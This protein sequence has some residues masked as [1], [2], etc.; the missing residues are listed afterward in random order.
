M[1][2]PSE[3]T[4]EIALS[5]SEPP[6]FG[7]ARRVL[8]D[9]LESETRLERK[10]GRRAL[11][12][13]LMAM[14]GFA[15][16]IELLAAAGELTWSRMSLPVMTVIVPAVTISWRFLNEAQRSRAEKRKMRR[17][18]LALELMEGSPQFVWARIEREILAP[19]KEVLPP[20]SHVEADGPV[21]AVLPFPNWA[22]MA[23]DFVRPRNSR[24]PRSSSGR[25]DER[26]S[27]GNGTPG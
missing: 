14:A 11:L 16:L 9:A 12:F 10:A 3:D 27:K 23:R 4:T 22:E 24:T 17:A 8:Q 25:N 7:R 15:G 5:G 2:S 1:A 19:D 13:F 21:Q 26:T 6:A 20:V 18:G